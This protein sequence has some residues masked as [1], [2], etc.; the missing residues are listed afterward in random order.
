MATPNGPDT[1]QISR[2]AAKFMG[3]LFEDLDIGTGKRH[4]AACGPADFARV[5]MKAGLEKSSIEAATRSMRRAAEAAAEE[6]GSGAKPKRVPNSDL[7]RSSVHA[8]GEGKLVVC[9]NR[10]LGSTVRAAGRS[11]MKP[12]VAKGAL[13]TTDYG[14]HGKKMKEHTRDSRPRG[15]TSTAL[16]YALLHGIGEDA[17]VMLRVKRFP[18]GCKLES[19]MLSIL[20]AAARAG[21]LPELLL[22]DRGFCNVGCM[23]AA[24]LQG[25]KWIMPMLKNARVKRLIREHDEGKL[26][27]AM[28]Y[29][30]LG[31]GGRSV[32]F[33]LLIV[34]KAASKGESK[35]GDGDG[36]GDGDD[37]GDD[38]VS[39]YVVFA[40]NMRVEDADAAI[41]SIPEEYR[42]RWGI[43]TGIKA[44]KGITGITTSNSIVLRLVLFF[45]PLLA[46]NLWRIARFAIEAA[47][48]GSGRKL[49][50][51]M[52]VGGV[53]EALGS[54]VVDRGK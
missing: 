51:S 37:D 8:A 52:F 31:A 12:G 36:D 13:D 4:N 17:N 2:H 14:Y 43:E 25:N 10:K 5:V 7:T 23:L 32:T 27:R 44:V 15:G 22:L 21:V 50:A 40:T 18:R 39:R 9:C 3:K 54:F 19:I 47:D 26:P 53:V 24:G 30:M 42:K 16:S 49:T 38:A 45:V 6:C 11:G 48:R 35:D 20:A 1:Q 46:Y 34:K 41:E 29:T 33:T 28:E